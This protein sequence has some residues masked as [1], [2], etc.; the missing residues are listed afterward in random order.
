MSRPPGPDLPPE[1]ADEVLRLRNAANAVARDRG[2]V[3]NQ[4]RG[5]LSTYVR[6]LYA[7]GWPWS[8]ISRAGKVDRKA[9]WR[10]SQF[11]PYGPAPLVPDPPL[12][13]EGLAALQRRQA[14]EQWLQ[15]VRVPSEEATEL[16]RLAESSGVQKSVKAR[17]AAYDF[18]VLAARLNEEG[19]SWTRIGEAAGLTHGAVLNRL[20]TFSFVPP[21]PSTALYHPRV[22]ERWNYRQDMI[23]EDDVQR[24]TP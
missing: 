9:A 13:G 1:V 11:P 10:W 7:A 22:A 20:R 21:S 2:S 23:S 6:A 15:A 12:S 19:Y 5:R 3:G 14:R 8:S 18:A 17:K 4:A 24:S 16:R